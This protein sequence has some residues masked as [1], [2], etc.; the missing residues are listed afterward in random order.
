MPRPRIPIIE[1][2]GLEFYLNTTADKHNGN[3]YDDFVELVD[4]K[5]RPNNRDIAAE[6]GVSG[7]TI[8]HWIEIFDKEKGE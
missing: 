7:P 6:F 8:T 3:D 4:R 5:L 1:S 2:V